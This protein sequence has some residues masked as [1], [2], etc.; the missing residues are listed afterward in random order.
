MSWIMPLIIAKLLSVNEAVTR[1]F[2]TALNLWL[3]LMSIRE[4]IGAYLTLYQ[5]TDSCAT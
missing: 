3:R 1:A 5:H 4:R 2:G